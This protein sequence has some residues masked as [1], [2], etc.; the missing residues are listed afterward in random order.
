MLSADSPISPT[1]ETEGDSAMRVTFA[2]TIS[3]SA[4]DVVRRFAAALEAK[5]LMGVREIVPSYCS[6]TIYYDVLTTD[7][8]ELQTIVEAID[9]SDATVA[10]AARI[11]EIPV[12]YDDVY[13]PDLGDVAEMHGMS[14][15]AVIEMHAQAEYIVAAV[16]FVP[17]FTYLYGL[18]PALETPR[19]ATPRLRVPPGSVAIGGGQTGIYPMETPGGWRIIGNTPVRLFDASGDEP[20]LLRPGDRVRFRRIGIEEHMISA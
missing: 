9:Y 2:D 5:A 3:L 14:I 19:L 10:S 11:L 15:N 12:C 7:W 17:G 13:A 16:G 1:I 20:A 8:R 18:P 6:V 4:L